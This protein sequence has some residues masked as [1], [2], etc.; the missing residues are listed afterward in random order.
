MDAS[1]FYN[2]SGTT[3]SG[4]PAGPGDYDR[5]GDVDQ[6]DFAKF[7]LCLTGD[8]IPQPDPLCQRMKF[9]IDD[10]VD[11]NDLTLWQKCYSGPENASNP[12]CAN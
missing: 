10:D 1:R 4:T 5:D 6:T 9:D 12:Y 8:F 2:T 3:G 7:Q 11:Q